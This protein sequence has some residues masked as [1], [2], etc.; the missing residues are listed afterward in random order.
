MLKKNLSVNLIF[1]SKTKEDFMKFQTL[2]QI[3]HASLYRTEW[4]KW[5]QQEE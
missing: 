3:Q 1:I 4:L 5:M 2:I